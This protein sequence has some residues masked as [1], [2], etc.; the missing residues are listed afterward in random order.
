MDAIAY[1]QRPDAVEETTVEELSQGLWQPHR[2]QHDLILVDLNVEDHNGISLVPF[3]G[4]A[5]IAS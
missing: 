4:A 1:S 5:C 2:P 3:D